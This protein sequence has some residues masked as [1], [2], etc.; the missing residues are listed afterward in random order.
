MTEEQLSKK[1]L[2]E[3]KYQEKKKKK[4]EGA[5]KAKRESFFQ[6][7]FIWL[8]VAALGAGL[9]IFVGRVIA[10]TTL[11][12]EAEFAIDIAENEWVRGNVESNITLV[13]YGDFQCPACRNAH[14]V[15]R[16]LIEEHGEN[17]RF[18][19]R[20]FPLAIHR[21]A[22]PAARAAEAAGQQGKFFEMKSILFENQSAWAELGD[23]EETF[24]GYARELGLDLEAFGV[25]YESDTVRERIEA[26]RQSGRELGITGVPAFFLNGRRIQLDDSFAPLTQA[27]EEAVAA[28]AQ[29]NAAEAE[30]A[31]VDAPETAPPAGR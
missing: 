13:E 8:F 22:T 16:G 31:P 18:V 9:V 29:E 6:N 23:P 25:A 28:Q 10:P 7:I 24:L 11:P 27:L 30:A 26:N 21:N 4:E 5:L 1:E 19:Y 14:P 17:V 15:V 2:R 3:R 20:H 12:G